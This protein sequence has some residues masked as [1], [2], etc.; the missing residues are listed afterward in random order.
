MILHMTIIYMHACF[1]NIH[2]RENIAH[3][4]WSMFLHMIIICMHVSIIYMHMSILHMTI[5]IIT[6]NDT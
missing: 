6:R 5:K 4:T 2:A 3:E 1:C